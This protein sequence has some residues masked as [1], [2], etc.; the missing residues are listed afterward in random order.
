MRK[1]RIKGYNRRGFPRSTTFFFCPMVSFLPALPH[2]PLLGFQCSR[3]PQRTNRDPA[4][5]AEGRTYAVFKHLLMN[6]YPTG[7]LVGD[8]HNIT[9]SLHGHTH[10][11]TH[12]VTDLSPPPPHKSIHSLSTP[13][14]I[15]HFASLFL[16]QSPT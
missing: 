10:T 13:V 2:R 1:G 9:H 5:A 16:N 8:V 14:F 15:A 11:Y 4:A 3:G 6:L 12:T 7:W